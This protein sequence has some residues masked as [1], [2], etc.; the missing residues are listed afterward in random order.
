MTARN[1]RK[2]K[3]NTSTVEKKDISYK[4]VSRKR[5]IGLKSR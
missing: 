4:N 2:K 1:T 5:T 3:E